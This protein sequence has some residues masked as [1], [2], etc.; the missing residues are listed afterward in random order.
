MYKTLGVP[1]KERNIVNLY[2]AN[3]IHTIYILTAGKQNTIFSEHRISKRFLTAEAVIHT[4]SF[5]TIL[6]VSE[7][8]YFRKYSGS[9]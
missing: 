4:Y 7:K 1:K 9:E 3:S 8:S 5:L 6:L 2:N